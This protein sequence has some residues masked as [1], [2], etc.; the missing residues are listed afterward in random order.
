MNIVK[1]LKELTQGTPWGLKDRL[2][3]YIK[4]LE[5]E[6][7]PKKQRTLSQNNSMWLYLTQLSEELNDA[8]L[9]MQ[10]VVKVDIDWDKDNACRYLWKPILKAKFG[11]DST[12]KQTK[13]EVTEV[14]ETL[15]RLTSDKF[16]LHVPF[17]SK[18]ELGYE[19]DLKNE[20]DKIEI[21]YPDEPNL[22]PK[23]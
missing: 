6:E 12:A 22:T 10:K 13:A 1:D 16:G 3:A 7:P 14:Y 23:F 17:P 18:S 11:K 8:G 9:P 2:E 4:K 5:T 15:N 19:Q 20:G 21:D